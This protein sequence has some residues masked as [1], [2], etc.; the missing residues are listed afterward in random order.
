MTQC[1]DLSLATNI[2]TESNV[3]PTWGEQDTLVPWR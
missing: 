2:L 1:H 3:L